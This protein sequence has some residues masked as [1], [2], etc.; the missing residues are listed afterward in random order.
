MRKLLLLRHGQ[1]IWNLNNIFTGWTNVELA[2][3]GIIEAK[4][5]GQLLKEQH[6]NIDI[7]FSSYLKRAIRSQWIVL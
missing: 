2:P 4:L 5:V 6:I 3:Q 1:S 7:C